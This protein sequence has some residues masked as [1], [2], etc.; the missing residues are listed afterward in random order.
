MAQFVK[1]AVMICLIN[2][3]LLFTSTVLANEAG[4]ALALDTQ[5]GNCIA[6][7]QLVSG[8][9]GG[10]LGPELVNIKQKYPEFETLRAIIWDATQRFPNTIMPPYGKH[11]ILTEQEIDAIAEYLYTL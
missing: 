9:K 5:Q 7:H 10:N 2:T 6:C 1:I 8:K 3:S 4:R 11:R